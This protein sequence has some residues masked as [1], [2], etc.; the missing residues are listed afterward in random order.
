[1]LELSTFDSQLTL[2]ELDLKSKSIQAICSAEVLHAR[3]IFRC[4][5]EASLFD[6]AFNYL[7]PVLSDVHH[8][9]LNLKMKSHSVLKTYCLRKLVATDA[10]SMGKHNH[11]EVAITCSHI[12]SEGCQVYHEL[13]SLKDWF[14]FEHDSCGIEGVEEVSLSEHLLTEESDA[15]YQ[16]RNG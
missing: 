1:M 5:Q 9:S 6:F 11:C 14:V 8:T 16:L 12:R 2:D 10:E 15:I 4:V 7:Y 13:E 3:K